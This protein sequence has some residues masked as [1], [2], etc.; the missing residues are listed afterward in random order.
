MPVY[1]RY[2]RFYEAHIEDMLV[3]YMITGDWISVDS[4]MTNSPG[5]MFVGRK[6][7][8]ELAEA[9]CAES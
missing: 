8:A 9:G 5:G 7:V 6:F 1:R 2:T 3:A 4:Q